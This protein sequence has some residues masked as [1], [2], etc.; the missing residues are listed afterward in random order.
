MSQ[1]AIAILLGQ[2]DPRPKFGSDV[3]TD[4]AAQTAKGREKICY[5]HN[6]AFRVAPK[7][8]PKQLEKVGKEDWVEVLWWVGSGD[9]VNFLSHYYQFLSTF[10]DVG[11]KEDSVG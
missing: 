8:V 2:V 5:L 9:R 11:Q 4:D 3:E 7:Q 10:P 1:Q 6:E